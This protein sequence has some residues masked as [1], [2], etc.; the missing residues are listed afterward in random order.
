MI[1]PGFAA[2]AAG[3]MLRGL[4]PVIFA[5]AAAI[6]GAGFLIGYWVFG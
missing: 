2:A 3:E 5:I 4:L 1:G 6:A